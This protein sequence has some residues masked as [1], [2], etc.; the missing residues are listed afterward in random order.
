MLQKLL[1]EA[2]ERFSRGAKKKAVKGMHPATRRNHMRFFVILTRAE[3]SFGALLSLEE[4]QRAASAA[5]GGRV[6]QA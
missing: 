4:K 1:H 2:S 5:K 6:G 3:G